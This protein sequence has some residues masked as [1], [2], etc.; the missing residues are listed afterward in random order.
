M[1]IK[2]NGGLGNQMFQYAH[3]RNLELQGKKIIFDTSFF[4]GNRSSIDTPRT[5]T[6]DKLNIDTN[7]TFSD[8]RHPIIDT[9]HKIQGKMGI[10]HEGHFQSEKYF[11]NIEAVIR[12]EFTPKNP[13]TRETMISQGEIASA[14]NSVCLHVRRGDYVTNNATNAYHG[15]CDIEYYK[16]ALNIITEKIGTRDINIFVFSDDISWVKENLQLPYPTIYA[17]N[18]NI[19][20]YEKMYLMSLCQHNIIA[21]SSFSWWGAWLNKNKGKIVI[22]PKQWFANKTSTELDILPKDWIAI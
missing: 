1:I 10:T 14:T 16:K 3:G 8:E 19:P 18:P 22:A 5:F 20:D 21:N 2:I 11:K 15:T 17:D 7:A 4:Y 12:R 13:L 9:L 6:L